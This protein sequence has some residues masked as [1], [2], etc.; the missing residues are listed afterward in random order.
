MSNRLESLNSKK[1]GA[2]PA[3]KF[4]PKVV[5]RKSKEDREK[6]APVVKSEGTPRS[7]ATRGRGGTRGRGRGRGGGYV[8]T[9][10]VSS[11][12]LAMGSVSMGGGST[13]SK[14]GLTQDRIY[15]TDSSHGDPLAHLK[16]KSRKSKSAS[17]DAES[18]SDDDATKINMS[19]EYA[20]DESEVVLFPIR[21]QKDENTTAEAVLASATVLAA[22]S[23]MPTV[24]SVKSEA[25][26]EVTPPETTGPDDALEAAEY[27]RHIDDQREIVDMLAAQLGGLKTDSEAPVSDRYFVLHIPQMFPQ[28]QVEPVESR[29]PFATPTVQTAAG[30]I[31]SLNFHK[32]G[33]ITINV[34]N[35]AFEATGGVPSSFLQEVVV[36]E[37][38][39]AKRLPEDEET[40]MLDADGGKIGGNMFRL[41]DVAGKI[42]ATPMV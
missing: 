8:G 30:H 24:E 35:T 13:N 22:T 15:G 23:R 3:L 34:G 32:L 16:L 7:A 37:S 41:G 12:P 28:E 38:H 42:V 21:P 5:A 14:T 20:F 26:D 25:L 9:H 40:E 10:L 27:D 33:K 29:T 17:P 19:K 2:K 11:G 36:L 6:E 1:T 18:D 31:G 39:E 4:K